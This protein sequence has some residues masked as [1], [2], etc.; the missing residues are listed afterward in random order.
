[1][2][3]EDRIN[4][5]NYAATIMMNRESEMTDNL[6]CYGNQLMVALLTDDWSQININTKEV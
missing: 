6:E 2:N 1:M 3:K 5:L 4:M